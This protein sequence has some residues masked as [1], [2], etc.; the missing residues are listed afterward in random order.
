MATFQDLMNFAIAT[1]GNNQITDPNSPTARNAMAAAINAEARRQL[2]QQAG[3]SA[4]R[5][6]RERQW[7][8]GERTAESGFL[9]PAEEEWVKKN[10]QLLGSQRPTTRELPGG[11]TSSTLP[12]GY[13][14][15]TDAQG[16]IIGTNRPLSSVVPYAGETVEQ[17]RAAINRGESTV[18]DRERLGEA[19]RQSIFQQAP[20]RQPIPPE[21]I[22]PALA[23]LGPVAGKP[24]QAPYT[25]AEFLDSLNRSMQ[26]ISPKDESNFL[27]R[28]QKAMGPSF[29]SQP[30]PA[31]TTESVTAPTTESVTDSAAPPIPASTSPEDQRRLK[32][33][34]TKYGVFGTASDE[35]KALDAERAAMTAERGRL[36]GDLERKTVSEPL[37]IDGGI[38]RYPGSAGETRVP[39]TRLLTA[40]ESA[41]KLA[42]LTELEA[43]IKENYAKSQALGS[44]RQSQIPEEVM[45]EWLGL[46]NRAAAATPVEA[47]PA[48]DPLSQFEAFLRESDKRNPR[49]VALAKEIAA[50]RQPTISATDTT[51][52][53]KGD[54][55]ILAD[56]AAFLEADKARNPLGGIPTQ[57]QSTTP[58]RELNTSLDNAIWQAQRGAADGRQVVDAIL[59]R[60]NDFMGRNQKQAS[61]PTTQKS[62]AEILDEAEAYFRKGREPST[63]T[64][65]RETA[66]TPRVQETAAPS[67]QMEL[68]SKQREFDRLAQSEDPRNLT[69]LAQLGD[70]IKT[71]QSQIIN[72]ERI[73]E[74]QKK[75]VEKEREFNR[76][77]ESNN[78]QDLSK[79]ARIGKEISDLRSQI[80]S[81]KTASR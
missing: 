75:L 66:V 78:P 42:R 61:A 70:E 46:R 21:A 1:G 67:P 59:A 10:P 49:V 13:T 4:V 15:L 47:A 7:L 39:V 69:R 74:G 41:D 77:A 11:V 64:P 72:T 24:Q 17:A 37:P 6:A 45:Q 30:A 52:L 50:S 22:A 54:A 60:F 12:D 51:P 58:N 28:L 62:D 8:T 27:N 79:L 26:P 80:K 53:A 35:M 9:S 40:Q 36:L 14:V 3:K 34:E 43:A 5:E 23:S 68:L 44:E 18:A 76:L 16:K 31:P 57:A 48:S 32:F 33:L 55:Q 38:A 56:F 63:P 20:V 19:L 65:T 25:Q 29:T 81:P 73:T 71:L 2:A